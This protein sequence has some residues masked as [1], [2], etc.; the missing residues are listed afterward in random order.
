MDVWIFLKGDNC[1]VIIFS[2]KIYSMKKLR[3]N[4]TWFILEVT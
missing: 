2:Y 4:I 1:T 3:E